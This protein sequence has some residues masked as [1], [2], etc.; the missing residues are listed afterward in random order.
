MLG[1]PFA[2]FLSIGFELVAQGVGAG[3]VIVIVCVVAFGA[4]AYGA[5][6][7]PVAAGTLM[8]V[9]IAFPFAFFVAA[10]SLTSLDTVP[11]V[12]LTFAVVCGM[13][14]LCGVLLVA[15]GRSE[16][17][18]ASAQREPVETPDYMPQG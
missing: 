15:A 9:P 12:L 17:R 3:L 8:I 6:K 1:L 13:P 16:R 14:L 5:W 18:T 10:A 7:F 11:Q 4:I 2:L